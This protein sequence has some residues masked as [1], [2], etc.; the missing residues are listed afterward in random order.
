MDPEYAGRNMLMGWGCKHAMPQAKTL[1][2]NSKTAS[3]NLSKS[4]RGTSG[5]YPPTLYQSVLGDKIT[6]EPHGVI[7]ILHPICW[8][9]DSASE[10]QYTALPYHLYWI[11]MDTTEQ[12]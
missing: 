11:L 6:L 2:K 4:K 9:C 12:P 7:A 3:M 10:I 8:L 5:I 1:C